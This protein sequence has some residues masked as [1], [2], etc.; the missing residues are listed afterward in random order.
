MW[1][2]SYF[3]GGSYLKQLIQV[4]KKTQPVEESGKKKAELNELNPVHYKRVI[5]HLSKMVLAV[6]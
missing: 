5:I 1:F 6:C 4:K 3:Q 2:L